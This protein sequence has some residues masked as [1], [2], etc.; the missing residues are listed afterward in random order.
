MKNGKLNQ[1]KTNKNKF[2]SKII[3]KSEILILPELYI[4]FSFNFSL[5]RDVEYFNQ[6][7]FI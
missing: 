5:F 3:L 7:S 4:L 2:N 1:I 6:F